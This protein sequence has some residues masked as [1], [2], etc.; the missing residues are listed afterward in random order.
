MFF[1]ILFSTLKM[2]AA[3]GSVSTQSPIPLSLHSN[4][5][6][7]VTIQWT[8]YFPPELTLH[9]QLSPSTN[10]H[11]ERVHSL[12]EDDV[13]GGVFTKHLVCRHTLLLFV[14]RHG[15]LRVVTAGFTG[16]ARRDTVT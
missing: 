9:S 12:V 5:W 4:C 1:S 10:E 8:W 2:E 16:F 11:R 13:M 7:T 14:W 6:G 3:P 15:S